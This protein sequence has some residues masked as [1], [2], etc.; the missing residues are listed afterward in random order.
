MVWW[1]I[2][3]IL[4]VIFVVGIALSTI[5]DWFI[6]NQTVNSS[7]GEIIRERL[8]DGN[9]KVVAGVFNRSGN[10]TAQQAWEGEL[11]SDLQQA[12]AGERVIRI[13]L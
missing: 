2:P 7:Y 6:E 9:Y 13:E 1:L 3:A 12:F 5:N 8:K 11:D 4:G 10:C